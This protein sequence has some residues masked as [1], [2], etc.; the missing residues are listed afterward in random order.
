[1]IYI[2]RT[3]KQE[4]S[5]RPKAKSK[6]QNGIAAASKKIGVATNLMAEIW[7]LKHG[8]EL[9]AILNLQNKIIIECDSKVTIHLFSAP[10][11]VNHPYFAVHNPFIF[12]VV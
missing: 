3:L 4:T 7:A 12:F 6:R 8:P 1:M 10:L 5:K 2:N 11:S 9:A